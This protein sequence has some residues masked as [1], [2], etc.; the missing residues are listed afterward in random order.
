MHPDKNKCQI[1]LSPSLLYSSPAKRKID[2][3]THQEI[4][5]TNTVHFSPASQISMQISIF[6]SS[7][8]CCFCIIFI[9]SS[10]LFIIAFLIFLPSI[11]QTSS[12]SLLQQISDDT[13]PSDSSSSMPP[14]LSPPCLLIH[15]GYPHCQYNVPHNM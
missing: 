4:A 14:R 1:H 2:S 9:A 11:I 10:S 7:L 3:K 8:C 15:E 5:S 13:A 6:S 12:F